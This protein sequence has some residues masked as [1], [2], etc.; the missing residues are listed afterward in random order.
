M[1]IIGGVRC[2]IC[3]TIEDRKPLTKDK[4]PVVGSRDRFFD[5]VVP[6]E[7]LDPL[8]KKAVEG[9]FRGIASESEPNKLAALHA[10]PGC[11][12]KVQKAMR[13]KDFSLLPSGPFKSLMLQIKQKYGLQAVRIN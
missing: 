13:T 9:K 11:A 7:A 2:D 10:C 12:P 1:K 3:T 5:F 8:T 4:R 6:P